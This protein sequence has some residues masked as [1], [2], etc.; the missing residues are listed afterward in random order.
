MF[1]CKIPHLLLVLLVKREVLLVV[2]LRAITSI[3]VMRMTGQT[4]ILPSNL[5]RRKYESM[6]LV[7]KILLLCQHLSTSLL[8]CPFVKTLALLKNIGVK[9]PVIQQSKYCYFIGRFLF[10]LKFFNRLRHFL[11]EDYILV[12]G[13]SWSIF[14]CSEGN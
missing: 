8:M 3:K 10:E 9:Y 4:Q 1:I 11:L 14:Y 5:L 12:L 6:D 7:Q 2:V 13:S